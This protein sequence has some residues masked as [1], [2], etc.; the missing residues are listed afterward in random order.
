MRAANG[1]T[2][3]SSR[4]LIH[5]FATKCDVSCSATETHRKPIGLLKGEYEVGAQ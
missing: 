5:D 4:A 2:G 3:S 1:S